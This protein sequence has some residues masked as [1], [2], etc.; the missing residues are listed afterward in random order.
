LKGGIG[1]REYHPAS[2]RSIP[3]DGYRLGVG[4][5]VVDLRD[6]NWDKHRVLPLRV[7]L[8]AGQADVFVPD[9]VCVTGTTHTGV[10]ESE[11]AGERND[12]FDVD[13]S[14]A[15]HAEATP[16]LDID[17]SVDVGQLRVLGT[18]AADLDRP[19]VGPP[20]IDEDTAPLRAAEARACGTG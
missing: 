11:V 7:S 19:G 5:L 14:L 12:G 1:A 18:D 3:E 20:P 15:A 17:A 8:G 16:R 9:R 2:F 13:H 4:R 10:G 6:L